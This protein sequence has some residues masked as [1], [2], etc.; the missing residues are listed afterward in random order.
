MPVSK[1]RS[2]AEVGR[3]PASD[4]PAENLQAAFDLMEL[5]RRL[6]PW[7]VQRGVRRYR[8]VDAPPELPL[9]G[10]TEATA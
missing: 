6:R 9:R 4:S 10:G 2:I 3:P 8:S 5:C 7:Q 1:Y